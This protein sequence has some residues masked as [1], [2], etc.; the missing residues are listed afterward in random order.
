V[1]ISPIP[2][3]VIHGDQDPIVPAHHGQRLFELA[4]EP[5]Q[6]WI[7]PDGGHIQAFRKSEYRDRFVA[8]LTEVLSAVSAA[9]K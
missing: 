1:D 2:L 7:V 8:W 3:L 5:K 6:I 4:R 9:H